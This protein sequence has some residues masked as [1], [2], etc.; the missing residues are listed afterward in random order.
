[1]KSLLLWLILITAASAG[2]IYELVGATTTPTATAE[3]WRAEVEGKKLVVLKVKEAGKEGEVNFGLELTQL[4]SF[5]KQCEALLE[6]R[7]PLK[8]GT[9]QVV[10]TMKSGRS[11]ID[12]A[13]VRVGNSS[14]W[15]V[16]VVHE[17]K[18][19]RSFVLDKQSWA[20][21]KKLTR[22]ANQ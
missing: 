2:P 15:R 4:I 5:E 1:M 20:K 22:K 18:L 14:P 21:L 3:V 16:L 8:T 9:V 19:E 11:W 12:F 13:R 6:D 10:S 17:D 7:T